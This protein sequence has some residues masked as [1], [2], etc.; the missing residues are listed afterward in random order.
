MTFP[1][2]FVESFN[3]Y[4]RKIIVEVVTPIGKVDMTI[5]FDFYEIIRKI[6][7]N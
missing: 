3:G 7:P 2:N 6:E 5:D 1:P 4:L